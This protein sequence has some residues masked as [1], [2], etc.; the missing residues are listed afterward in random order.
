MVAIANGLILVFIAAPGGLL[1]LG[2]SA[3][4]NKIRNKMN[5][6]DQPLS[7]RR[8]DLQPYIDN[9]LAHPEKAVRAFRKLGITWLIFWGGAFVLSIF[10]VPPFQ[11]TW[12]L[13]EGSAIVLIDLIFR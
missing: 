2:A 1:A 12:L 11:L 4:Q 10:G 9:A 7:L 5:R 13:I 8:P 3:L 6:W